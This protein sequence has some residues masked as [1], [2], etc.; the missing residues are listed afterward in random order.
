MSLS[1][2]SSDRS[3]PVQFSTPGESTLLAAVAVCFLVLHVL[4]F[5]IMAPGPQ[6]D[7]AAPSAPASLSVGD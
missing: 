1:E 3:F 4:A 2:K 7:A 6:S 5:V